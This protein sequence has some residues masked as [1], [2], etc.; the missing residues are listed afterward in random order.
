MAMLIKEG[1]GGAGASTVRCWAKLSEAVVECYCTVFCFGGLP[2]CPLACLPSCHYCFCCCC[3]CYCHRCCRLL[4][5]AACYC[6]LPFFFFFFLSFPFFFFFFFKH[7]PLLCCCFW[8]QDKTGMERL[9]DAIEK[10]VD[11]KPRTLDWLVKLI[12]AVYKV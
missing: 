2:A 10:Y 8:M 9:Q 5:A 7:D 11:I 4:P 3:C 1:G 6:F 12:D